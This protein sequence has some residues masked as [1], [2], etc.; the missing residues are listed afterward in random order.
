MVFV[1]VLLLAAGSRSRGQQLPFPA[2]ATGAEFSQAI[3]ALAEEVI[4][5]YR[6]ADRSIYLANLYRLQIAAGRYADAVATIAALLALSAPA[7]SLEALQQPVLRPV[8]FEIYARAR[9]LER[10]TGRPFDEAYDQ[11]FR[12]V[13]ARLSDRDAVEVAWFLGS[14]LPRFRQELQAAIDQRTGKTDITPA[15]AVRLIAAYVAEEAYRRAAPRIGTLLAEDDARRFVVHN[16]VLISTKEGATLSAVVVRPKGVTERQPA[17]LMFNIYVDPIANRVYAKRAAL[18]G[19]AGIVCD[20]HGKGLSPDLPQPWDHDVRDTYAVID[21]ISRQPW[22]DGQVGMYGGSYAG[23]SQWA[24]AKSLHPALKTIVPVVAAN[25]GLGLPMQNNV[26]QT[27]NYAWNFYVA[28]NK[29]LDEET[30]GDTR[31]WNALNLRWFASGRPYREIDRI[32]GTPNPILQRQ[33]QHPAYDGYWQSLTPYKSEFSRIRIPV[34]SIAGYFDDSQV[35]SVQYLKDHYGYNKSADHYLVIGPYDHFGTQ[36]AL[37]PAVARG[38]AIDPIAQFDTSELTFQWFDYVMRR[39][40]RPALLKDKIN[41]QVM[42]ANVW[43]HAPSLAA[44]STEALTLYLTADKSGRYYVARREKPAARGFIDQTIDLAD[45][46]TTNNDFPGLAILPRDLGATGPSFISDPFEA[47]VSVSGAVSGTLGAV[48]NARDFDFSVAL[49]GMHPDGSLVNLTYYLGRASF[50]KDMTVRRLLT[51]GKLESLPF[52]RTP[53][54]SRQMAAGSRLLVRLNVNKNPFA[55]VNYGTGK[56]VSDESMAD[57]KMP[58]RI[59]WSTDSYIQVP[60]SR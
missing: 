5:R 3:P 23:F 58:L 2:G 37:K 12:E 6:D 26:F 32:D 51:P 24:A 55:Q 43:R 30:Y 20:T 22:S 34:L 56:D 53:L 52:E 50:A 42:G 7:G 29:T 27:P 4:P 21:W 57:A 28:N 40:A 16:D 13:F 1:I 46:T 11:A 15:D 49:Y 35:S 41:Y 59:Q 31:R 19:Y 36:A 38:Y 45:R 39:G 14:P 17:A 18:R 25:P 10:D 54:T 47:P 8:V 44:M 9:M 48:I 60:I 33:L